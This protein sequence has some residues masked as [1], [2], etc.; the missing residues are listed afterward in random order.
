MVDVEIAPDAGR[1][2]TIEKHKGRCR[3]S[4]DVRGR[5]GSGGMRGPFIGAV[6]TKSLCVCTCSSLFDFVR[7]YTVHTRVA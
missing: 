1:W 4:V 6:K 5:G 2:G 7:V 3:G